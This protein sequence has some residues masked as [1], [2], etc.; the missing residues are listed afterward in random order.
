MKI[1]ISYHHILHYI[2]VL[3]ACIRAFRV[4]ERSIKASNTSSHSF[5]T[6]SSTGK[7]LDK[8]LY[9]SLYFQNNN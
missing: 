1:N 8:T 5:L 7:T 9:H 6:Y 4:G 3:T 2:W